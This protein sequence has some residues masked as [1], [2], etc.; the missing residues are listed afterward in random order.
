MLLNFDPLPTFQ[1][2]VAGQT[3][4]CEMRLG[5]R[6]HA[7][8]IEVGDADGT[9]AYTRDGN[10]NIVDA[11]ISQIRLKLNGK[12]Q[13]TMSFGELSEINGLY[14]T[15]FAA[16]AK[17]TPGD[18]A[19]R[20]FVTIY[21]SEWWRKAWQDAILGAWNLAG[22]DSCQ[23]E[24][25]I[26]AGVNSP[27]VKGIMFYDGLVGTIGGI[28]KWVR[29]SFEAV[30]TIQDY[31]IDRDPVTDFIQAMHLFPSTDGKFIDR[32]KFTAAGVDVRNMIYAAENQVALIGQEM[33]PDL[34]DIPR[35]D[36]VF[37]ASDRLNDALP[38]QVRG[39]KIPD[40]TLHVE[41]SASANGN[42]PTISE[43]NG[44]PI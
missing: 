8:Q 19:Y 20:T 14:G 31:N 17:G 4:I 27:I 24:V 9:V 26:V 37:D 15:E 43:R 13:R 36:I 28:T 1:G 41:W 29:R 10:G 16:V 34:S 33:F 18:P 44:L 3:A 39:V 12:P 21:L 40:L 23:L 6:V 22:V 42:L 25:D 7:I 32:F 35:L 30:G 38:L 5:R 2:I 11:L